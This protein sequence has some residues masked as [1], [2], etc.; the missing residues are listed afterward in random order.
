MQYRQKMPNS[1]ECSLTQRREIFSSFAVTG[2]YLSM[3]FSSNNHSRRI[4]WQI[5]LAPVNAAIGKVGTGTNCTTIVQIRQ[6][7]RKVLRNKNKDSNPIQLKQW[8]FSIA[9][10]QCKRGQFH[11]LLSPDAVDV[12]TGLDT[13][14]IL[15]LAAVTSERSS[16]RCRFLLRRA[17]LGLF[18]AAGPKTTWPQRL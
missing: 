10:K 13:S 14:P 3:K 12:L 18:R 1:N 5:L 16:G 11:S 2:I 9:P 7:I 17:T 15:R 4:P 6:F 8:L